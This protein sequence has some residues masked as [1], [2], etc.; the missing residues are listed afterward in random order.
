MDDRF[1]ER[2]EP[3][4]GG[5]EELESVPELFVLNASGFI[6]QPLSVLG[7]PGG[8]LIVFDEGGREPFNAADCRRLGGLVRFIEVSLNNARLYEDLR[9]AQEQLVQREK[10]SALGELVSGVAH[11]LN[12]PLAT[13]MG[14]SELLE[15]HD[16][17]QRSR[18]TVAMIR[19]EA[20][21]AA[22]IVRNLLT[23][24]RQSRP[25]LGWHDVGAVVD[26][27]VHLRRDKLQAASI[28]L[29]ADLSP[30]V[31][32]LQVDTH[33]MHQVLVNLVNNAAHAI[34]E[35]G[36]AGSILVR[37]Y[38]EGERAFIEV[39][40]DGPGIPE[41]VLPRIFNPF[42]TT[43]RV[44]K[45][46]GLGLSICYGI[47]QAHEGAFRVRSVPGQG[48]T[49]TIDLPLPTSEQ[50]EEARALAVGESAVDEREV[51]GKG[52]LILI[53]DD[54]EGIRETLN[55]A[56]T[57]WGFE[58][59]LASS[60][61]D[62]LEV[63]EG[64]DPTLIVTDLRMPGLDGPGLYNA[65]HE[66]RGVDAPPFVF[67]TGDAASDEVSG[68]LEEIDSAV[69]VKPFSLAQLKDVIP[70]ECVSHGV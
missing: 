32:P 45:G 10:L 43:K 8:V 61:E 52:R 27:I 28:D 47:V 15:T 24:S 53:V 58:T 55:E 37:T 23:F 40:D 51:E 67:L 21:R 54:E 65:V 17:P 60:G 30:E 6:A 70:G 42:F 18:K 59:R 35:A 31:P 13:V 38:R 20:D 22:R 41:D 26:E 48:A 63:M 39:S 56:F 11:E 44:G 19:R 12:N 49:F 46:T 2:A 68:F 33:Q 62:A 14:S 5:P 66:R 64:C 69:L 16:L 29:R 7:E 36:R 1:L 4:L 9:Q 50:I 57:I 3:L 34:E 25:E